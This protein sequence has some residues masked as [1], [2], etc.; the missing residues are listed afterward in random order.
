MTIALAAYGPNAGKAVALGL[1]A[2]EILGRG[3]IAGFVVVSVLDARDQHRQVC[4]Q[5]GGIAALADLTGFHAA[6]CAAAI[7]S[8]P[9]RPEPLSQFLVGRAGVGLVT[10]HRL[11][12]RRERRDQPVNLAVLELMAQGQSPSAAVE[13]TLATNAELDVGLIA[14]GPRGPLGFGNTSRVMRRND[15]LTAS[16][17]AGGIGYAMLCNSIFSA[18]DIWLEDV[19]GAIMWSHLCAETSPY[20]IAD[21]HAPVPVYP[22]SE[23]RVELDA[24]H[25]LIAVRA[26][27]PNITRPA[28]RT[29]LVHAG[30]PVWQGGECIGRAASEIFASVAEGQAR[31]LS[32]HPAQFLIERCRDVA[33]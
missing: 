26:A 21:M 15:V 5:S 23:D 13:V 20:V 16:R 19:V 31:T 30:A 33:A 8:G 9:N 22:D 24:D 28:A 32:E 14:V 25:R 3:S 18:R 27:E 2:A 10:G 12:N 7:S 4:C 11:P 17:E 1:Q 6:H 29:T